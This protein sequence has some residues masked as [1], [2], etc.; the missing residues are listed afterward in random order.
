M[1]G[2]TQEMRDKAEDIA[3]LA[4]VFGTSIAVRSEAKAREA[5]REL[6]RAITQ[7]LSEA[8]AA[9]KREGQRDGRTKP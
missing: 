3:S 7:G 5:Y 8:F 4:G 2:P 9:G 1:A 6:V